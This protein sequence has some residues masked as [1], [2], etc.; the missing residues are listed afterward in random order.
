MRLIN[1]EIIQH[2]FT[3]V[4]LTRITPPISKLC[5]ANDIILF[6]EASMVELSSLKECL[7][8]YCQWSGKIISVEKS[9]VF[10]SKGVSPHF[11]N[12][13][14]AH[15]GL[16]KLL[17]SAKYLGI[18]LFLTPH[19][20]KDFNDIKELIKNKLSSWKS[21]NLSWQGVL[22]LSNLWLKPYPPTP[23]LSSNSL[24]GFVNSW[25]LL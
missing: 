4:K 22:L 1:K 25:M 8:K 2:K 20:K 3:G 9:R 13:I 23:C 11:L 6:C 17:P 21:K 16:S 12:Q 7:R 10:P 5:Y 18:P 19:R 15:W 14:Q 24:K